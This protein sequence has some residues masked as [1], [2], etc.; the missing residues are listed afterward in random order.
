MS[1]DELRPAR[2]TMT[3]RRPEE[4][5]ILRVPLRT[6]LFAIGFSG[7]AWYAMQA[8]H[9]FGHLAGAFMTG[10]TVQRVVLHPLAISRTDIAPNPH[11]VIVLWM[12]PM[13]GCLLPCVLMLCIPMRWALVR[14]CMQVFAGFCLVANGLYI[15]V[16][17]LAGIGDS[18]DLL[19]AGTPRPMLLAF[20][21]LAVCLGFWL[22]HRVGPLS[23][24]GKYPPPV[25]RLAVYAVWAAL[26][27]ATAM[28]FLLSPR[29]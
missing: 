8:V 21:A 10:G 12:G 7:L 29:I 25:S 1:G 22:W 27:S 13:L 4:T 19:Q 15:A 2:L 24:L 23:R 9:E 28:G 3:K 17:A 20:G 16:G 6:V 11:P 5:W 18:R 26:L 14:A